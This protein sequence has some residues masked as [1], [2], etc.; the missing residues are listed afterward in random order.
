MLFDGGFGGEDEGGTTVG[1]GRGVGGCY[2]AVLGFEGGAERAG[3]GLVELVQTSMGCEHGATV[4][5]ARGAE[6]NLRSWARRRAQP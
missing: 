1:E 5:S 2:G 6:S 4:C 3:F